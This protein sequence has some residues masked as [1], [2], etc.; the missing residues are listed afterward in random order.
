MIKLLIEREHV[1]YSIG[2]CM[3]WN[4]LKSSDLLYF[5]Q[6]TICLVKHVP[7]L[8]SICFKHYFY[9]FLKEATNPQRFIYKQPSSW[10]LRGSVQ[11]TKHC[12]V[13][14]CIWGDKRTEKQHTHT[15]IMVLCAATRAALSF[16]LWFYRFR[17]SAVQQCSCDSDTD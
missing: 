15:H 7:R 12:I 13:F 14:P 16:I 8:P 6:E 9:G 4:H 5:M 3:T 2:A 1:T 17:F 11:E 10:P